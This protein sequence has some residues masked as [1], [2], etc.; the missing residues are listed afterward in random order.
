MKYTAYNLW[1]NRRITDILREADPAFWLI[2]QKSSFTTI[3][4][5]L[6]HIYD[7]ETLWYKRLKGESP[8]KW[9]S[10][11]YKGSNDD[12]IKMWLEVSDNFVQ[13]VSGGSNEFL[14]ST[15]RFRSLEGK[16]YN[17]IVSDIIQHCMN[18]STFHRGQ[19]ITMMRFC[20]MV[21]FPDTDYVIYIREQQK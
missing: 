12:A 20:G 1:A 2:E 17:M 5:T 7:A 16:E 19:L 8:N 3:R 11:D 21:K 4:K 10:A 6:L 15:C 13:L 18:H 14:S 9:P